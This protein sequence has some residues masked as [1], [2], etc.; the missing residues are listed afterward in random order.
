MVD[1]RKLKYYYIRESGEHRCTPVSNELQL[2]MT[3]VLQHFENIAETKPIEINLHG[4]DKATKLWRYWMT[5]EP[6]DFN[7]LLGNGSRLNP[8]VELAKKLTFTSDL[9]MAA[10]YSLLDE[11]LP[12]EKADKIKETTRKCDEELTVNRK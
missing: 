11:I 4:T 2:A 8:F 3:K 7:I 10:I 1:V 5:Q 9:T 12:K 6:A